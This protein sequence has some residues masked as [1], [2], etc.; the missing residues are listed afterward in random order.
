MRNTH[1]KLTDII[2]DFIIDTKASDIPLDIYSHAKVAFLDWLGVTLA[3]KDESLVKKL[4][5]YS[6][7]MG[8]HEQ[9]TVL[10]HGIKK[11]MAHAALIN[12]AA[13]HA[14]DYDDML[15]AIPGHPAVM[16]FPALLAISEYKECSGL[17][18]LTAFLIGFKIGAVIGGCTG[19]NHYLK[20]WH[21]TSTIGHFTAAAVCC[22]ILKLNKIQTL[23]AL[24]IA[25]TQASGLKCSFGT[26]CKPFHPGKAA[27]AGL[28]STLLASDGFT[29]ANNV[30]EAPNGF[31]QALTGK[32]N[33]EKIDTLGKTWE[34]ED[35]SQKYH[36]SCGGTHSSIEASRS[37]L[38]DNNIIPTD[39]E[40]IKIFSSE[41]GIS[42]AGKPD[43]QT[44]LE[45]KFSIRYCA[46]NALL[47]SDTGIQA[48]TDSRVNNPKVR[49]LMQ[50][51]TV[52]ADKDLCLLATRIELITNDGQTYTKI[53]DIEKDMP[54]LE[55][56]KN[57]VKL[58]FTDLC[59]PALGSS[60]TNLIIEDVF[61]LEKIKNIKD[62]AQKL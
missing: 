29:G 24:G 31:F 32:I 11:N 46:A 47:N 43:P 16:T 23:N 40:S 39:I 56:R 36:A 4:L 60:K 41:G 12:G 35:L 30:L 25:G 3:G 61:A 7:L 44:G 52:S 37:I 51:I 59:E 14:L 13:S 33:Q 5:N 10:W 22:R 17:E 38:K 58:K 45:G 28:A 48:F 55:G 53:F 1:E 50:K 62:F 6:D 57:K 42:A 15:M 9:A 54:N 21:A 19:L 34:I 8:G 26:M 20:G 49:K 18:F 2:A 27:E